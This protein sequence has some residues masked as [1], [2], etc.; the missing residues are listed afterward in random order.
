ME[1][2]LALFAI[3]LC[4]SFIQG[5]T[6]FGSALVSIPLLVLFIDIR[7]AVPLCIL[8]GLVI[9]A[10]LSLQLRSHIDWRKIMPLLIGFLPGIFLGLLFL[11]N[12]NEVFFKSSLSLMLI[13]Y[14]LYRLFFHQGTGVPKSVL[15]DKGHRL[16][17]F[18]AGFASGAI[19]TAFSA[20]GPPAIIYTTLTGWSKDEIKATLS[21][22]FFLGGLLTALAHFM[23]GITTY[24]VVTHHLFS[25]PAI[26]G[27]VI[28]GS[29][30]YGKFDTEGYIRLIL[31]G[32][33]VTGILLFLSAAGC[34]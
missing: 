3:F 27:G 20:G 6:G 13:S 5:L 30:L 24:E 28:C 25:L 23:S 8:N 7:T 22:Y 32:L 34:F 9:T 26:I 2:T 31:W 18:L 21:V 14:A 12:T 15:P 33:I 19:T 4:S 16:S 10:Y 17:A 11:K 29:L 1:T